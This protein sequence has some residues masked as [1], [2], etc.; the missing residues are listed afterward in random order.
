MDANTTDP[1]IESLKKRYLDVISKEKWPNTPQLT[2]EAD[3][4]ERAVR[5]LGRKSESSVAE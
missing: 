2:Q 4:I 1:I 3:N 5:E